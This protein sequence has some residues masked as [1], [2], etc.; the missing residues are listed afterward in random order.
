ME[1]KNKLEKEGKF[2]GFIWFVVPKIVINIKKR[3]L[4]EKMVQKKAEK[5]EKKEEDD[6]SD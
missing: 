2:C 4:I 1:S 5:K 3:A 6:K